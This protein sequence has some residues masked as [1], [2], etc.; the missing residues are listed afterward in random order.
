MSLYM[1]GTYEYATSK[2]FSLSEFCLLRYVI[3]YLN[4]K[5]LNKTY[6]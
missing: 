6:K 2:N 5:I 4:L 3:I 1:Y